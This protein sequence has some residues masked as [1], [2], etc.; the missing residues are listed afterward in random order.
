MI[1]TA[2]WSWQM[3]ILAM[4]LLASAIFS[5][6]ETALFSLS[7][8]DRKQL[9]NSTSFWTRR[10][11]WLIHRPGRTLNAMLLGNM[12]ANI[13]Y[14]SVSAVAILDLE[15]SGAAAWLVAAATI[16]PLLALIFLG[17][18]IPKMLAYGVARRW[19]ATAGG[20]IAALELVF[21]PILWFMDTLLVGPMIRICLPAPKPAGDI[22]I[23]ELSTLTELSV[24]RGVVDNQAASILQEIIG[25]DSR[26]A[27]DVMVP[28]VEIIACEIDAGREALAEIFRRTHLRKVPI[29]RGDLDTMLGIVHARRF[30]TE[31]ETPIGDLVQPAFYLP[32]PAN[33]EQVLRQFRR[34][35]RQSA[36]VVDEYG[37]TAGLITLQDVLEVIVGEIPG[38]FDRG[39]QAIERI[40]DRE[41]V[42]P[43]HLP[44]H[45][46]W[47]MVSDT[48]LHPRISTVGGYVN[49]LLGR[50]PRVGDGG[51][52]RN[53]RFT[54][55]SLR[56]HGIHS[57]R[58]ELL[59][60]GEGGD[61]E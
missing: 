25:L 57:V 11:V 10:T 44:I 58:I 9:E 48:P 55:L 22:S 47:S 30:L 34:T 4:G 42:V 20:F 8:K 50:L 54:V 39:T 5:G 33:L 2:D 51:V 1:A 17:E 46:W 7:S 3:G 23:A 45:D 26:C 60:A 35:H 16:A 12:I 52:Y 37:G 15:R 24:R 61:D 36:I 19:A 49:H 32:E 59:D 13:A 43:G 56:S 6:T 18:V 53:L 27:S 31:P 41:Y 40:S 14:A 21:R 28:R 29:Y 38:G